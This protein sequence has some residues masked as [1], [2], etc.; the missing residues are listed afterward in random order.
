M[1]C[2]IGCGVFGCCSIMLCDIFSSK[3]LLRVLL[4]G[5]KTKGCAGVVGAEP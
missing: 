5:P 2:A 1:W 3:L 4:L